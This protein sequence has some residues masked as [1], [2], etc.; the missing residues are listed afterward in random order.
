VNKCNDDLKSINDTNTFD[1]SIQDKI[2]NKD[3]EDNNNYYYYDRLAYP[4]SKRIKLRHEPEEVQE[5]IPVQY[6]GDIIVEIKD[7]DGTV[8]PCTIPGR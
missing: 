7:R 5:N 6:T 8:V 4:F 2:T 1:Y 3:C